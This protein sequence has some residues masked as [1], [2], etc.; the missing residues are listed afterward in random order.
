MTPLKTAIIGFGAVAAGNDDDPV[1]GKAYKYPSHAS[2]L[3]AH[4]AFDWAAVV[5]PSDQ[6]RMRARDR[7]NIENV[8]AST[9][10]ML[11][12]LT[13]DVVVI[14]SPPGLRA[15]VVRSIPQLK[16][17]MVEKPLGLG[18]QGAED[19]AN[20]CR[21]REIPTQVN[22]WRR[23]N[24]VFRNLASGGLD[25]LIGEAQAVFGVYGN[26]IRNNAIHL[27]DFVRMLVGEVVSQH[28]ETGA[29][30][31]SVGPIE[32]DVQFP[33]SL[34]LESGLVAQ[35]QPLD[36]SHFRENG[37]DIWG[38]KGRLSI[39]QDSRVMLRHPMRPN[40]GLSGNSEIA[41]ELPECLETEFGESLYE[42]YENLAV[43]IS[44]KG[45]LVSPVDQA[46]RAEAIV[47]ALIQPCDS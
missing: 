45:Q 4:P 6:A 25:D 23:G 26:G 46:L 41:S 7:W 15:Q 16:G 10:E 38:T 14:A 13:P 34:T 17:L 37:L 9:E 8:F 3:Q 5:D 20:L 42:M 12:E 28:R 21:E 11:S 2:A 30:V 43:A 40:R 36:F 33:F 44:G 27:I 47:D 32:G 19:F 18:M 29:N 1:M 31:I 24:R 22:Y 35:M 39:L